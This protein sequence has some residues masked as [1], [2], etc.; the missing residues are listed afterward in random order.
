[1]AKHLWIIAQEGI[2]YYEHETRKHENAL[3]RFYGVYFLDGENPIHKSLGWAS[4]GWTL[5][6][7]EVELERVLDKR[8]MTKFKDSLVQASSYNVE[9]TY[10]KTQDDFT[11]DDFYDAMKELS[12]ASHNP[13]EYS[14]RAGFLIIGVGT[15][16]CAVINTDPVKELLTQTNLISYAAVATDATTL[17]AC[18][19]EQKICIP[20]DCL[21]SASELS[22][23]WD[24]LP[25]ADMVFIVTG[26]DTWE[27]IAISAAIAEYL[28][29]KAHCVMAMALLSEGHE[30]E[31]YDAFMPLIS[32]ANA[33]HMIS[34][35]KANTSIVKTLQCIIDVICEHSM[36]AVD[37]SDV[38]TVFGAK[39]YYEE[40]S[41]SFG[42]QAY[43]SYGVVYG[44]E[45]SQR[46]EQA[47]KQAVQN[48]ALPVGRTLKDTCAALFAI[49]ASSDFTG[50]EILMVSK[51]ISDA[52]S[53]DT[54]IIFSVL[55]V[56]GVESLEVQLITVFD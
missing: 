46:A 48:I 11:D 47:A 35:E 12:T 55:F 3:D 29:G 51:T 9:R 1:M 22:V 41:C 2:R 23:F 16:G 45:K 36:I 26:G 52:L 8:E 25:K 43:M 10:A 50:E 17:E 19:A 42:W 13:S 27:D 28:R 56:D 34:R 31:G 18:T 37:L 4:E 49:R 15:E 40:Q 39:A 38:S 53:E 30:Q 6:K 14:D 20:E 24:A 44:D 5:D 54:N 21:A 33:T 7:A 32:V